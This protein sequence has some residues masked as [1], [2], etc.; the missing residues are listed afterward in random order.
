M[1]ELPGQ[2]EPRFLFEARQIF[3]KFKANGHT[4]LLLVTYICLYEF[5]MIF[6][7]LIP[8]GR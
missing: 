8:F 6:N 3:F 5:P 1:R 7:Q 2:N 4:V